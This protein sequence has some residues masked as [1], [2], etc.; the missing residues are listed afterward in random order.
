ME[1]LSWEPLSRQQKR[2]V[3]M[4]KPI[5]RKPTKEEEKMWTINKQDVHKDCRCTT[6]GSNKVCGLAFDLYNTKGD[7]CL[8]EK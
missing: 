7:W 8:A 6:C 3:M 2:M 4:D 1:L 5:I